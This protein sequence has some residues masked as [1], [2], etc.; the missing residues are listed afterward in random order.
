MRR[1]ILRRTLFGHGETTD[2]LNLK[3]HVANER[4]FTHLGKIITYNLSRHSPK[5]HEQPEAKLRYKQ[6]G[7][8]PRCQRHRFYILND[9]SSG[10]Y[11]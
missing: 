9:E 5:F 4:I 11:H 10:V 8:T 1:K 7:G 3:G 6:K 2:I